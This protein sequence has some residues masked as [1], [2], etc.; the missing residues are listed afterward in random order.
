VDTELRTN[1][2][3]FPWLWLTPALVIIAATVV[4]GILM[5]PTM[6]Q[7]L[8]VHY[9]ASG[10]PN[11]MAAKSVGTAF[12]LVFVQLGFTA[13]LAGMAAA[14]VHSRPDIDPARPVGSA[15]WGRHYLLLGAKVLLGLVALIDLGMLG[16]SLLMW[17]G[18]TT[19][20]APLVVV[21]PVLTGVVAAVAVLARNN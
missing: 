17:T 18:T 4:A 15:R 14:I 2:P 5:Y 9:G 16:S 7:N 1:P 20:W 3:R 13:L 19:R 21:L 6:P 10:A 11:R 12:S 8:A